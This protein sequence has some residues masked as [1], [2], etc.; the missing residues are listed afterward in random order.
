MLGNGSGHGHD[1][2]NDTQLT[3]VRM[4]EAFDD[5]KHIFRL[6]CKLAKCDH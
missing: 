5:V 6:V 1:N 4:R 3:G 2:V